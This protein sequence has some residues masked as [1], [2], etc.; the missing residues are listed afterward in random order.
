[1]KTR[2]AW[3]LALGAL[4]L[5]TL[6]VAMPGSPLYL[7]KFLNAGPRQDGRTLAEWRQDLAGSD[8]PTR[9]K[10]LRALGALG[11]EA[12]P[13]VADL[14]DIVE[15]DDDPEARHQAALALCKM[16]P[17]SAPAV[18]ALRKAL[19]DPEGLVRA[20]AALALLRLQK[21][22]RPALPELIKTLE[23]PS[24][25]TNLGVFHATIQEIA[26]RALGQASAGSGAGV[27][28]LTAALQ[29]ARSEGLKIALAQTLGELGEFAKPSLPQLRALLQDNSEP[30]R[31]AASEAIALIDPNPSA[32]TIHAKAAAVDNTIYALPESERTY[33]WDIEHHGNLLAKHGFG[34]ISQALKK[35]DAAALER[36]LSADF[37][38]SILA[39][40]TR[41]RS[42]GSAGEIERLQDA[43]RPPVS[44]TKDAFLARLLEYRKLFAAAPPS[45]K[46]A[47][48]NLSP[49]APGKLDGAWV[50]TGQLRLNGEHA[51]GAPAEVILYLRYETAPLTEE[52]LKQPGWLR[53]AHIYQILSA[54]A[55][56]FL[57][58]D[59]TRQRGI[60][61]GKLHDNWHN[62]PLQIATG[63]AYVCDFNHDG[64]L[65]L[66]ITD[67]NGCF[68]Y[69]GRG[70]GGFED[71]TSRSG[72]PT[73]PVNGLAT[74]WIDID[75]DGWEDLILAGRIFRNMEGKRF[76]DY[77]GRCNL[78]LPPDA[79]NILVADYDRDGKL[80]MYVTR[81]GR[82]GSN[83]WLESKSA[84][85]TGNYL[86]RNKG[87]WQFE[88]VT[89]ASG[90]AGGHRSTFTAAWLDA[91]NDGWPDLHVANEFGDGILLINNRDGT[92]REQLLADRPADFGTMGLAVGDIDNDGNIDIYC[93]NM[94]SK[95]GTRVIGN[96]KPDAFPPPVMEKMRRFVG[97]SQ[98]HLN[99]GG[100]KFEQVGVEKRVNGIGWAY[101][102]CLA[103]LD[104]DGFLDLYAT[105]GFVSRSRDLPDG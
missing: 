5:G 36:I 27:P 49:K 10:A 79:Q 29:S 103:D 102:A 82:P 69:Q 14:A 22:A 93:A 75:G 74:A 7:P 39:E 63:G 105:A 20:N 94:F 53:S 76:V 85:S 34:A 46:L 81:T 84:D 61:A 51:K 26:A 57:F 55:P 9:H 43:G 90:A 45:V 65:D 59:V 41:I 99:K 28:A 13:A 37:T 87:D 24:N 33:I 35:A 54:K 80:D 19:A 104:N 83:S 11:A 56:H 17:A 67:I 4:V 91:D 44:L 8:A 30:V 77:T 32:E 88:D 86:F 6:V 15:N 2:L 21:E 100:L 1:M 68:L 95:A 62:Q 58:A 47:L 12:A 60:D 98:L 16:A 42:S 3:R 101:G 18:S 50:G 72:L 73:G 89:V 31:Q 23:D 38:G 64:S 25:Q 70:D 40:P 96:L 52:N 71:V 92:F 78:R 66:L 48:M 97:G